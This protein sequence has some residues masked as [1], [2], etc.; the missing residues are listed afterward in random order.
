MQI[1]RFRSMIVE[2]SQQCNC[3][4]YRAQLRGDYTQ[5]EL[6][7]SPN[8]KKQITECNNQIIRHGTMS[9]LDGYLLMG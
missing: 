4:V 1:M 6:D 2:L 7:L 3:I 5:E 9:V 8:C